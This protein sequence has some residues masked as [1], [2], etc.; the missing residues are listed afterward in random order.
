MRLNGVSTSA[1]KSFLHGLYE[2][3]AENVGE[4]KEDPQTIG[5][6]AREKIWYLNH[7]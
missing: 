6:D 2:E 4:R 7:Y 1:A 3:T 5:V